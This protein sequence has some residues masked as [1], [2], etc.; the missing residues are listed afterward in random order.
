MTPTSEELLE[1]LPDTFRYTQ[2]LE[3]ISERQLRRLIADGQVT[4]MSRGLHRKSD[5]HGDEDLIEIAA[6]SPRATI[7]LRSGPGPARADRRHP[8]RD[9][10]RHPARLMDTRDPCTRQVA[11]LRSRHLRD[12][13]GSDRHRGWPQHRALLR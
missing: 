2:A 10:H 12:R 6:K 4:A 13:P 5:W 8:R 9:R 7:C 11:A 3:R 1:A